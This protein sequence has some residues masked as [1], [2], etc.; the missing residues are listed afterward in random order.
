MVHI[1]KYILCMYVR[2][3]EQVIASMHLVTSYTLYKYRMHMKDPL[4]GPL[5]KYV[6]I[7]VLPKGHDVCT[8][9]RAVEDIQ[10]L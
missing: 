7:H 9:G 5:H 10:M 1:H 2:S 8:T 6:C 3:R 4:T